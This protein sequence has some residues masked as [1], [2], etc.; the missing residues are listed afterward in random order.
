MKLKVFVFAILM[1]IVA[2]FAQAPNA[3]IARIEV[4]DVYTSNTSKYIGL[5]FIYHNLV[6]YNPANPA[7]EPPY[8]YVDGRVR[9]GKYKASQTAMDNYLN[10]VS[11]KYNGKIFT[12]VKFLQTDMGLPAVIFACENGDTLYYS[13]LSVISGEFAN[14]DFLDKEK[15][16]I[17]SKFFYKNDSHDP[18]YIN[19]LKGQLSTLYSIGFRN[20]KT[21]QFDFFFPA[22]SEWKILDVS[23]DTDYVGEH[24]PTNDAMNAIASRI[25]YTVENKI[26]GKYEAYL[27]N[28]QQSIVYKLE[29]E[30]VLGGLWAFEESNYSAE[31]L[32]N[33]KA[34][35]AKGDAASIYY[36][37]KMEEFKNSSN[38]KQSNSYQNKSISPKI[39][40]SAKN[41]YIYAVDE[42]ASAGNVSVE[43]KFK[44]IDAAKKKYG[45]SDAY[46]T[47][48]KK[49]ASSIFNTIYEINNS[50]EANKKI[51]VFEKMIK[52]YSFI[53]KK[54]IKTFE[55]WNQTKDVKTEKENIQKELDKTKKDQ[56]QESEIGILEQQLKEKEEKVKKVS[57]KLNEK[58][59]AIIEEYKK[60]GDKNK[61]TQ[62]MQQLQKQQETIQKTVQELMEDISRLKKQ[63]REEKNKR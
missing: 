42:A 30:H 62:Q 57:E 7:M 43:D 39:I 44:F 25:K 4:A 19:T 27:Q 55:W 28:M 2:S 50:S 1:G 40:E 37:T 38:S 16:K 26:Y 46:K 61:Y 9:N 51:E 15:K 45:D 21:K 23:F 31:D 35:A 13:A 41:G 20:I 60:T 10:D 54:G 24:T 33:L 17:G 36:Q 49:I 63:I 52:D 5:K 53:E 18:T 34:W 22:M 14:K 59:Q 8:P 12:V 48:E 32:K 47:L 11:K 58:Y 29:A 3:P 56:V 6:K